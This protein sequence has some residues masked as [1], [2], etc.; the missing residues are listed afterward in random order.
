MHQALLMRETE[1][2]SAG[3]YSILLDVH[4][5][6][7]FI[8]F[9]LDLGQARILTEKKPEVVLDHR[10]NASFPVTSLMKFMETVF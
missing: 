4:R 8:C 7:T 6:I 3:V 9:P 1:V 10:Q 2:E 5:W